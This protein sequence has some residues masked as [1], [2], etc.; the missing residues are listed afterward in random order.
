MRNLSAFNRLAKTAVQASTQRSARPKPAKRPARTGVGE[1]LA[2][3]AV[4]PAG[5]RRYRLYRPPNIAFGER[6]PLIVMLH[7]C[8]QDANSFA[9][10]TRMNLL[11]GRERF[12]V[13]YPEQDRLSNPQGCW[14]WFDTTG[15]R[16][17]GEAALIMSAITQ[18]CLVHAGDRERVAVAG[19]SAGAS[20]AALLATRYPE[21]F[22]AVTMHS[23]VPP[24]TAHSTLSALGAMKGY[25]A[26]G[27][28][29]PTLASMAAP[30][31]PLQVIHGGADSVVA[32]RNG[33]AA[34]QLWAEAAGAR[35]GAERTVQRGQRYP[36]TVV[37]FR[38]SGITLAT[39]VEIGPLGHA[40]SGGSARE[41][42]S[43]ARGPDASRMVWAFAAKQFEVATPSP[44][45]QRDRQTPGGGLRGASSKAVPIDA[46]GR[47]RGPGV[48]R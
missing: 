31:P 15:G 21:S 32:A 19:M 46:S 14:N 8:G 48:D 10:S 13:L 18:V 40:W 34:V 47:A 12:L 20:M 9:A 4:G 43:D 33:R 16:A 25:G 26:R 42:Y 1:W 27:S 22:K 39:L 44:L 35:A 36:M 17:Q 41:P 6:L 37:D 38:R 2:G 5:L 28:R 11:A 45:R 23:G 24:G 30:W 3:V 29:A 7:G